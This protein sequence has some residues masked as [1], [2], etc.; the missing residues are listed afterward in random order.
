[1]SQELVW[2]REYRKSKLLTKENKPQT[3]VV[4]F[5]KFLKD[6]NKKNLGSIFRQKSATAHFCTDLQILDLGS[7][8]GRNSYY[9]AR[10][11]SS[12]AEGNGGQAELGAKVIGFE[13]SQTAINIAKSNMSR[14][15]LDIEYKKQSIGEKFLLEDNSIDIVLD[16]TSSNSLSE[17]EREVYL[18]ETNRVL[19]KEGYF[20]VK[21]L[22]KDGD[23]NAK[24]LLKNFSGKEK[25]TYI[26]PELGVTERVWSREDFIK[27]YEKYFT[28]LKLEKKISYSR[29]NNRSY[30]RNFWICYMRK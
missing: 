21:A 6:L 2:D 13:I 1:M 20:F 15:R 5:V 4:H 28:I 22:C 29:M 27:Y 24:Y 3:D 19:K 23:D 26:M 17:G 14:T 9:F 16:V 25:D 11:L 30:K 18:S 8:T 7:G 10:L 12:E